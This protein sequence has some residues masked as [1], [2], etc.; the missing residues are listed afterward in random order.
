MSNRNFYSFR[1]RRPAERALLGP[2]SGVKKVPLGNPCQLDDLNWAPVARPPCR[3]RNFRGWEYSCGDASDKK[4][5][6]AKLDVGDHCLRAATRPPFRSLDLGI[7][8]GQLGLVLQ[9][10]NGRA[11]SRSTR[12]RLTLSC[13]PQA[14]QGRSSNLPANRAGLEGVERLKPKGGDGASVLQR[15]GS[16]R[17]YMQQWLTGSQSI[18]NV[19]LFVLAIEL[20]S[21][22]FT[23]YTCSA[24][25]RYWSELVLRP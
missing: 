20:R 13:R 8:H 10:G 1:A 23:T 16:G 19:G 22:G 18:K 2:A 3:W 5:R 15:P 24:L 12:F 6:L 4:E 7:G 21:I 9:P 14:L 17:R 11:V 25:G